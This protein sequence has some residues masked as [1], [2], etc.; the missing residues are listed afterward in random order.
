MYFKSLYIIGLLSLASCAPTITYF[1][2]TAADY[3]YKQYNK[4]AVFGMTRDLQDASDFEISMTKRLAK[5]GYS[6]MPG[7]SIYPPELMK[8]LDVKAIRKHLL[9]KGVE[10]VVSLAVVS[11]SSRTVYVP[12]SSFTAPVEQMRFGSNYITT[13][14]SIYQPGY[15]TQSGT[16][17]YEASFYDLTSENTENNLVWTYQYKFDADGTSIPALHPFAKNLFE[18]LKSDKIL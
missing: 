3:D 8:N 14:Q 5:K 7:M 16:Y 13:Y 12:G 9:S 18:Q 15:Y 6:A 17:I 11:V 4:I 1:N 10:A 2:W